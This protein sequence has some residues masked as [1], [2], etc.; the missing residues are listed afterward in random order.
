VSETRD[1]L[2]AVIGFQAE[3]I[4]VAEALIERLGHTADYRRLLHR[5]LV[6]EQE[7]GA[8]FPADLMSNAY[9]AAQLSGLPPRAPGPTPLDDYLS[10]VQQ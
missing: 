3:V 4:T 6:A 9:N 10:E 8:L 5:R 1:R 7:A 2:V